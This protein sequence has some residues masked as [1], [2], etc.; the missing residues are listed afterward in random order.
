MLTKSSDS[1]S[2]E[3]GVNGGFRRM[4]GVIGG[5]SKTAI[6]SVLRDRTPAPPDEP[7]GEASVSW[8]G[9]ASFQWGNTE[10]LS[11]GPSI[12][13]NFIDSDDEEEEENPAET[14]KIYRWTEIK[15]RRQEVTV[16]ITG[17]VEGAY[18]DIARVR[19]MTFSAGEE[20]GVPVFYIL[21]IAQFGDE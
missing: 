8:G 15:E 4:V 7:A 10:D 2:I 11:Q 20:N 9:P 18:V 16:R 13:Y 12:T 14:E 1:F 6:T 3:V 21:E 5:A 17:N 19:E